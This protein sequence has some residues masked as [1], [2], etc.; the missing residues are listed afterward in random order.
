MCV[1]TYV[2]VCMYGCVCKGDT[3]WYSLLS[4]YATRRKVVGSIPDCINII[5]HEHNPSGRIM[6]RRLTQ[7]PTQIGASN[8]S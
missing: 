3:R 5:F 8:I 7:F 1:Y 6:V 4:H 2:C